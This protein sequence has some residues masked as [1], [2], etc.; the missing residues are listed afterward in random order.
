MFCRSV[1]YSINGYH[2]QHIVVLAEVVSVA[3]ELSSD[4]VVLRQS[5]GLLA[6]SGKKTTSFR[7]PTRAT[8]VLTNSSSTHF[9]SFSFFQGTWRPA[10]ASGLLVTMTYFINTSES[11]ECCK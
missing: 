6:D 7:W 4:E 10:K 1:N 11:K 9:F 5:P 2:R 3:L 8:H